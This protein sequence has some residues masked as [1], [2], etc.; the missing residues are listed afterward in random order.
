MIS[1][2][3]VLIKRLNHC[4]LADAVHIWNEGFIGYFVDMSVSVDAY[5]AR[6]YNEQLSPE[7]SFIAFIDGRPAGF[8]LNGIRMNGDERIAWNGGTGVSPEF[9][10]GGVGKSLVRAALELYREKGATIATLEAIAENKPAINLYQK[11]GYEIVDRLIFLQHEG[12]PNISESTG[13]YSVHPVTPYEVGRLDFYESTTPW[14]TQWQSLTRNNG[15]AVIVRNEKE[16]PVAYALYRKRYDDDG[17]LNT[18]SLY[19]CKLRP[20]QNNAEAIA[21]CALRHAFA[22]L[23]FSC[24]RTTNNL[25]MSNELICRILMKCGFSTFV[26]QVQMAATIKST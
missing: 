2:S 9:R 17:A 19:Q 6:L 14:Q 26:E 18:I 13:G 23:D 16:S 22:P 7:L 4:S 10:G 8:L 5:V 20:D 11:F 1:E 12:T 24:R 21:T 25:S 15:Q 3:K